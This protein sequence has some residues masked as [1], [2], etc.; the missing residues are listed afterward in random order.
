MNAFRSLRRPY[1]STCEINSTVD[2][3]A[4]VIPYVSCTWAVINVRD[5]GSASRCKDLGNL[6]YLGLPPVS[7]IR[8][9]L[10]PSRARGVRNRHQPRP[11]PRAWLHGRIAG[12]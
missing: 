2:D 9:V 3:R 11:A 4:F 5:H 7:K 12:G 8:P 10:V 6:W 1:A